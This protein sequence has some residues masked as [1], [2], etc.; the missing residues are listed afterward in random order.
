MSVVIGRYFGNDST[1]ELLQ[2]DEGSYLMRTFVRDRDLDRPATG[3]EAM[4]W[5]EHM[6]RNGGTVY[7]DVTSWPVRP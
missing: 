3:A 4:A 1:Q 7:R 6:K 5:I 2:D